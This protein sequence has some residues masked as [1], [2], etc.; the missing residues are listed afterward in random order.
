MTAAFL[1][2]AGVSCVAIWV[3]AAEVGSHE[4]GQR[5]DEP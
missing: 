3:A 2:F 1:F 5:E 4:L